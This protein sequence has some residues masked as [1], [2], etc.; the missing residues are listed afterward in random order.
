MI[1]ALTLGEHFIPLFP[2]SVLYKNTD[3][4]NFVF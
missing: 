4:L 1:Q 2:Y 3:W